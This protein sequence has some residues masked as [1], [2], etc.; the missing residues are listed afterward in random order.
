MPLKDVFE[1]F[2][3]S[4]ATIQQIHRD[5]IEYFNQLVQKLSEPRDAELK[6]EFITQ[7]ASPPNSP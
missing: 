1:D 4:K 7:V 2:K 6:E 5:T 3:K